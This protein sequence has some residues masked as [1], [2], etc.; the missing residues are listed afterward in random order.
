MRAAA[1]LARK[2]V[3]L[4]APRPMNLYGTSVLLYTHVA[5][6]VCAS[7]VDASTKSRNVEDIKN[8]IW[9]AL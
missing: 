9:P 2:K 4:H 5:V 7:V 3:F 8:T 1:L 6:H